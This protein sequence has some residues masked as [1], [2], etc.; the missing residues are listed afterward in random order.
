MTIGIYKI[1]NVCNNKIYIGKSTNIERRIKEHIR[2][3][4]SNTNHNAH[5][6]NSW[7]KYGE[8][9]FEFTIIHELKN[10]NNIN[11]W[12]EY[13][14]KLYKSYDSNF[15]YNFTLGGDG[16][17]LTE[18]YKKI[19]SVNSRF[20]NSDLNED[21]VTKVKIC[22]YCL[23]DRREISELL[24]VPYCVVKSIAEC[25]NYSYVHEELNDL[26]FNLKGRLIQERNEK[27]LELYNN[28]YR[29][30]DICNELE[31]S[32]S[33][34]EHIIYDKKKHVKNMNEYKEKYNQ[35]YKDVV[36]LHNEGVINYHISKML[37]I[38]PSTVTRY[39]NKYANTELTN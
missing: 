15:G 19:K 13:Y 20:K 17:K 12:E 11:Y 35:I 32:K 30:V 25:K 18:E 26:I 4:N 3:L 28:R 2:H 37:N 7:N 9:N 29:I 33:T 31:L 5:I 27:V 23:M 6:Q 10:D 38:S 39:L 8:E 34:V 1:K 16:G 24:N 21:I 36:R 22:L 14:I